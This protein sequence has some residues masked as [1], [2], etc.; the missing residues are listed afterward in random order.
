MHVRKTQAKGMRFP[1]LSASLAQVIE[2]VG[3]VAEGIT[4]ETT[5]FSRR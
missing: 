3:S 1:T 4:P 2:V 5:V